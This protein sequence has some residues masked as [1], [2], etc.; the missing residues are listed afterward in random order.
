MTTCNLP[1]VKTFSM[2]KDP[3]KQYKE[4]MEDA[5]KKNEGVLPG[6][7]QKQQQ[8][9]NSSSK[10]TAVNMIKEFFKDMEA[11]ITSIRGSFDKKLL[12]AEAE[13]RVAAG[14]INEN[15]EY[16][17]D[18]R[19]QLLYVYRK[20]DLDKPYVMN[21]PP[22]VKNLDLVYYYSSV[23]LILRSDALFYLPG[24]NYNGSTSNINL[25]GMI[26]ICKS[27]FADND[28]ARSF[29][30]QEYEKFKNMIDYFVKTLR[31]EN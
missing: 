15:C 20:Y 11:T 8:Y 17:H 31:Q 5:V 2:C 26:T 13:L 23:G 22:A 12:F 25:D 28:N 9:E 7:K 10:I 27:M 16:H 19:E 24:Y 3:I 21:D 18:D 14:L 1:R 30:E 29:Y 6:L 4:Y